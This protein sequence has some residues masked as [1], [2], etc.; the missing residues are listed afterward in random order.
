[1]WG[2][3][4]NTSAR[5][6]SLGLPKQSPRR[7]LVPSKGDIFRGVL[8]VLIAAG[9]LGAVYVAVFGEKVRARFYPMR[10]DVSM[11]DGPGTIVH[12]S[13]ISNTVL[14][15]HLKVTNNS[16]TVA[17]HCRLMLVGIERQTSSGFARLPLPVPLQLPWAPQPL[18]ERDMVLV[19]SAV[20][21]FGQLVPAE[22]TRLYPMS[23]EGYRG[24]FEP[25]LYARPNDF[26]GRMKNGET[27]RYAIEVHAENL[28][29]PPR[30]LFEVS[31]DGVWLGDP[32]AMREHLRVRKVRTALATETT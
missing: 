15:H 2:V 6:P 23:T 32:E 1:M 25:A 14:W 8:D 9:T 7:Q 26:A 12:S 3:L 29:Q 18:A 16:E 31:W 28:P 17:R 27:F 22:G 30:F 20:A 4:V 21:D 11:N 24:Y 5:T 13:V 19:H 10:I